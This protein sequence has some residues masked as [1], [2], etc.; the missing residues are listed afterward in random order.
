MV[1]CVVAC[2]NRGTVMVLCVL[3]AAQLAVQARKRVSIS[4]QES[5]ETEVSDFIG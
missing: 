1:L 3:Q 2:V 4:R 5:Q